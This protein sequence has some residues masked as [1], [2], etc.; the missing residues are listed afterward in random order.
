MPVDRSTRSYLAKG[1][2]KCV[3]SVAAL[4]LVSVFTNVPDKNRAWMDSELEIVLPFQ[5]KLLRP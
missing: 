2:G 1:D 5:A 4:S 3:R